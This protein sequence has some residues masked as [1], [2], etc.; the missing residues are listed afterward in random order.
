MKNPLFT[1]ACTALITPFLNGKVNYPMLEQLLK[2]QMEAGI[3]AVVICGT[4]GESPTLSDSEKLEMFR[5]AKQYVSEDCLIIAGTGSNC[6][7]HAVALSKAAETV[8]ADALLV[9][10]PY[11][12]KATGEGLLAHYSAIAGAV[13]IPVIAYNVPSRTGV[14]I[15]VEVCRC[16]AMIPNMAGIKE[17]ST[18]VRKVT[19][20]RAEC[21]RDFAVWSGND[22]LAAAVIAL[23]G[24]GVIS[25]LSNV[26]PVET[27]ALAQAALDGDFDTAADLQTRLLPLIEALFSEV[28]P[29][30]VKAA[31]K[32]IGYD[33][34]DCRLPLT[35]MSRENCEKLKKLLS[36]G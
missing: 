34:G 19:K 24:Q 17:A 10:S 29:I 21:P 28:N 32:L 36:A 12:N 33:C 30:P 9:V 14:D 16:L 25:V 22:D 23:G 2:R 8:G 13:H 26:A 6:T 3:R 18:D 1:G 4:T 35:P 20:I 31:M 11:Y 5:R 15:P 7:E 27:Q